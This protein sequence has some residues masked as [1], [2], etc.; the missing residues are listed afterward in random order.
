MYI[1]PWTGYQDA[2]R[3]VEYIHLHSNVSCTL[4]SPPL[5]TSYVTPCLQDVLPPSRAPSAIGSFPGQGS[6]CLFSPPSSIRVSHEDLDMGVRHHFSLSAFDRYFHTAPAT[7]PVP[8]LSYP[9]LVVSPTHHRL[10]RK[11]RFDAL[12]PPHHHLFPRIG[13]MLHF[14]LSPLPAPP[15][16]HRLPRARRLLQDDGA[17]VQRERTVTSRERATAPSPTDAS[18]T[19]S[20]CTLR[21]VS[22]ACLPYA[23]IDATLTVVFA[24]Q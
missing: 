15:S 8:P 24:R 18:L 5:A 2:E 22:R 1:A 19:M 10:H 21:M 20:P 23:A 9:W 17:G 12:R 3:L 14:V 6:T 11:P 13:R 16:C 7:F 4:L